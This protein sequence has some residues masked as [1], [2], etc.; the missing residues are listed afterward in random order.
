MLDYANVW[1]IIAQ[2]AFLVASLCVALIVVIKE[3]E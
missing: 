2:S 1:V 3:T